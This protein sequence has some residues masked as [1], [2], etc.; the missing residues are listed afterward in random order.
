MF[1][2]IKNLDSNKIKIDK[3]SY[4]NILI[5]YIGYVT[6]KDLSCIRN[7][8]VNPLYLIINKINGYIEESNG[9]KYLA[10][11]L[12]EE[13][14]DPLQKCKDLGTKVRDHIKSKTNNLEDCDKKYLKIKFNSNYDLHLNKTL[15]LRNMIKVVRSVFHESNIYYPQFF[16]DECLYNYEL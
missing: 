11:V 3:K 8:I 15:E 9:N 10:L 5:C 1:D 7:N 12:T 14:K 4:I 13:S 16:W 2:D 6:L